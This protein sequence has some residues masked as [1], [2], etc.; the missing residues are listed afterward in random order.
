MQEADRI[1]C[2]NPFHYVRTE[3]LWLEQNN[4]VWL[5]FVIIVAHFVNPLL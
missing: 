3:D 2:N 5:G 4:R 1:T